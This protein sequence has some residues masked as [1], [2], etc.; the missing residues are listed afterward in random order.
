MRI[1][2]RHLP[3]GARFTTSGACWLKSSSRTARLYGNGRAFYFSQNEP[4]Q[5][6][7]SEMETPK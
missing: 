6:D 2:F 4:V 5:V 3:I 1:E 7:P